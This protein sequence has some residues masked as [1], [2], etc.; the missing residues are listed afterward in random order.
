MEGNPGSLKE[1]M[2]YCIT[3]SKASFWARPVSFLS[4]PSLSRTA[5]GAQKMLSACVLRWEE[6]DLVLSPGS[7]QPW[8]FLPVQ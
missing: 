8:A 7:S 4:I 3:T 5:S 6:G 1:D 2:F